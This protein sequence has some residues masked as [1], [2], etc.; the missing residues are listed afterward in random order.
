MLGRIAILDAMSRGDI[1]ISYEYDLTGE[2][3]SRLDQSAPVIPDDDEALGSR[4]F[5]QHFF[6]DRL[7]ITLGPIV[8]SDSIRKL[9]GRTLFKGRRNHF[10]LENSDGN[11][12][13]MPGE[14]LTVHSME[15]ISVSGNSA[16]YILP[17]LT[18]A[19]VGLVVV[20]TYIDPH[21]EG[22]LQLY[23]TN[24]SSHAHS[25]KL[26]ERVAICRFYQVDRADDSSDIKSQFAQKSHH[27]G[28][29]WRRILDSDGDVQLR[30]KRPI[31]SVSTTLRQVA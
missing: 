26:G 7:G 10:N 27:F 12:E 6:G 25:L 29:N 20:P 19:T 11:I 3:P 22:I 16:A 30:K 24:L 13:I 1:S 9:P 18:L 28:L 21:W 15:Y 23:I 2:T 31:R 14:S 5:Q 8:I 4:I 17:R